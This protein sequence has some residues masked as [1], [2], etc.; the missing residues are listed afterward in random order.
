LRRDALKKYSI[1]VM[2]ALPRNP[3]PQMTYSGNVILFVDLNIV[4][5]IATQFH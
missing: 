3:M 2:A 1:F 5:Q 4:R